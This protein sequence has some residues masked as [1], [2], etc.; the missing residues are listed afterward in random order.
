MI[1]KRI[2]PFFQTTREREKD[3]SVYTE[4]SL[5]C[6]GGD[7]FGV[8]IWAEVKSGRISPMYLT[9]KNHRLLLGA[10]CRRC[11]K[12]ILLFDSSRDGYDACSPAPE[13][14]PP[15]HPLACKKCGGADFSLLLRYESPP[16]EELEFLNLPD[17]S[18]RFTW[19]QATLR[20][21]CCGAV[22][23]NFLDWETG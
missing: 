6:C 23:K 22:Y 19:I 21:K 5:S 13:E 11:G 12:F 14:A 17:P 7:C 4:V 18:N 10:R 1:P 2:L 15:L 9:E 16:V 3:G 20:C 8:D